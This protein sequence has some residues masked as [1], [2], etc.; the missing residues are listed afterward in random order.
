MA[1]WGV[2]VKPGEP[3]VHEPTR[4]GR[5]RIRQAT[6]GNYD[7]VGWSMLECN[8]GDMRPVRLC[9]MNSTSAL[10]CHLDL[11]YEEKE[12][13]VISVLGN[14]S[15]HLS[16]YYICSQNADQGHYSEKPTGKATSHTCLKR[17]YQGC[18]T[19]GKNDDLL[20]KT[21]IFEDGNGIGSGHLPI[22]IAFSKKK[23]AKKRKCKTPSIEQVPNDQ[24]NGMDQ[25]NEQTDSKI[26][27]SSAVHIAP[28]QAH[29]I[30]L[31]GIDVQNASQEQ[32]AVETEGQHDT[33][34]QITGKIGPIIMMSD[35]GA[36][37]LQGVLKQ[38]EDDSCENAHARSVHTGKGPISPRSGDHDHYS[39][40]FTSKAAS[41][42]C[43]KRKHQGDETDDK[44]DASPKEPIVSEADG[45]D[46]TPLK[47]H[48]LIEDGD[49]DDE[50]LPMR[51]RESST[52]HPVPTQ[53]HETQEAS[54]VQCS[55]GAI[56]QTT[57]QTGPPITA[58]SFLVT[59]ATELQGVKKQNEDAENSQNVD[60]GKG[61]I[62][63]T[64][65]NDE[66]IV[67]DLDVGSAHGSIASNGSKVTVKYVGTLLGGPTV[68]P[69]SIH[70][71]RLGAGR[72]I[73]GWDLGIAGMRVGGKR[74][75][76]IP[77]ALGYGGEAHGQIPA[78]SWLVYEVQLTKVQR[79]KK[80]SDQASVNPC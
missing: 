48:V 12:N 38:N 16:G 56:N 72:V 55:V 45:K 22:P 36:T 77:P 4:G 21:I 13:V 35:D 20:R 37:N 64:T 17:K 26:M 19:D 57:G 75:L 33:A 24:H 46:D 34:V 14:S 78:N 42:P 47:E 39:D 58:D 10:M 31:D 23:T 30:T 59:G 49:D 2:E 29:E 11:E 25:V 62:H 53:D 5:L 18:D 43:F 8:V 74:R 60:T 6:L 73:R 7:Y 76:T 65:L 69:K 61:S 67:E 50:H 63:K 27:V 28:S 80:A 1:F 32:N 66:L 79:C 52:M 70:K 68:D 71:F 9:A 54:V 44:N 51:V 40:K 15:I 3:Y 41:P